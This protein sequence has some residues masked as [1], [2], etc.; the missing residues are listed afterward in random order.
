MTERSLVLWK[1]GDSESIVARIAIGGDFL[2]AGKLESPR[3]GAWGDAASPLASHFDDVATSFVNLE[4]A[5]DTAGLA[6]RPPLGL[7]Q[8]VSAPPVALDYLCAI[9]SLAVGFANNHSYDFGAIGVERT[10]HALAHRNLVLLGAGCSANDPPDVFVWQGSGLKVGFWAAANASHDLA[11]GRSVGVEPAT[12]RRAK[13]ALDLLKSD[14]AQFSIALLHAG[15][16]RANRLDPADIELMDSIARAGFGI[17]AASHSHRIGGSRQLH[18]KRGS[19]AFCFYGLGSL[20]SGY[21]ASPPEREGLIVVAGLTACGNLASL[22]IRPVLLRASGFGE[23]PAIESGRTILERFHQLSAE[24]ADGSSKQ[25]F[26]R[27]ISQSLVKL[28]LRDAGAAFR[29]C[30]FRGLARKT[31]RI[32]MRHLRRLANGFFG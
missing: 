13:Q 12:R 6:A 14:G 2:P 16:V 22:E 26:Y 32:R 9:R 27:E 25:L 3:H 24:I 20:V 17:V 29:E 1:S 31:S 8:I 4:C 23:V 21:V 10:R 15:C 7:G 5:I 18:I 30:G 11:N 28:Y 19:P